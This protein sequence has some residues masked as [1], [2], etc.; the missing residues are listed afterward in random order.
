M[1][2]LNRLQRVRGSYDKAN[3]KS[4]IH[5]V[6]AWATENGVV[7]G[8][9]K[10]KDKSN[11]ITAIPKL[12]E[13]LELKGCIV[14]LDAMGCQ[15]SIAQ[16]I[17]DQKADYLFSLKGNQGNTHEEVQHYFDTHKSYKEHT[18]IDADHGRIEM[19]EYF[20]ASA[21]DLPIINEWPSIKSIAMVRSTREKKDKKSVESRYFISSLDL[22]IKKISKAIR[23]HWGIENSLHWVLDVTFDEDKKRIRKGDAAE[24]LSLIHI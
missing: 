24:N 11:E 20:I 21:V 5:M 18:T 13:T 16:N 17:I 23:S 15:K 9:V 10:V 7:L 2:R 1:R 3:S 4:A 8:Q 14:T 22:N 19:R 6:S 12:L